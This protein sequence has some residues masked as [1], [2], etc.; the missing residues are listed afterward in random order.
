MAEGIEIAE[1]TKEIA[2]RYIRG[3][4]DKFK[5]RDISAISTAALQYQRQRVSLEF[6]K[7]LEAQTH[8][9]AAAADQ[10]AKNEQVAHLAEIDALYGELFGWLAEPETPLNRT[11]Y[12]RT[13]SV[14]QVA[15]RS[16]IENLTDFDGT[17]E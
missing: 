1:A 9:I 14:D 7:F 2:V 15:F 6:D 4:H 17:H 13:M 10:H 16:A 5:D 11:V 3:V 12:D 8:I